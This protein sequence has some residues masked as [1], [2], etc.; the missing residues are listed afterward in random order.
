[1]FCYG[2]C[3][4]LLTLYQNN[5]IQRI[6]TV[7]YKVNLNQHKFQ[8]CFPNPSTLHVLGAFTRLH[9]QYSQGS[10]QEHTACG[11]QKGDGSASRA[12]TGHRGFKAT[13]PEGPGYQEGQ[14]AHPQTVRELK[15]DQKPG[16]TC[17]QFPGDQHTSGQ[18]SCF[19]A[20]NLPLRMLS[21]GKL[22]TRCDGLFGLGF[23]LL[24]LFVYLFGWFVV[25]FFHSAWNKGKLARQLHVKS[26]ARA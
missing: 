22:Q 14:E 25:F 4:R 1:M 12:G 18:E 5:N 15:T 16:S 20:L 26:N 2:L 23:V 13:G 11:N 24:V 17:T 9:W 7:L 19:R 6:C 10:L 8:C 3:S 21:L